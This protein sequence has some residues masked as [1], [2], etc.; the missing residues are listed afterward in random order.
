[1]VQR[2]CNVIDVCL[3]V[4]NPFCD[5]FAQTLNNNTEGPCAGTMVPIFTLL[6][7]SGEHPVLSPSHVCALPHPALSASPTMDPNMARK[8]ADDCISLLV[9]GSTAALAADLAIAPDIQSI[10]RHFS[11]MHSLPAPLLCFHLQRGSPTA[12][13]ACS[14]RARTTTEACRRTEGSSSLHQQ[15]PNFGSHIFRALRTHLCA[16]G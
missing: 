16:R 4:P 7:I 15:P 14:W 9:A 10:P 5:A 13:L 6:V 8:N 1:M 11:P 3:P 2:C 12:R